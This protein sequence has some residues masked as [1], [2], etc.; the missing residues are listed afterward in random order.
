[1]MTE[2]KVENFEVGA[3]WHSFHRKPWRFGDFRL[4]SKAQRFVKICFDLS[5]SRISSPQGQTVQFCTSAEYFEVNFM[6]LLF[7]TQ[8][9]IYSYRVSWCDFIIMENDLQID[10]V[11]A[12]ITFQKVCKEIS[13]GIPSEA[14]SSL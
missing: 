6:Q 2:C 3:D 11:N 1:M 13:G 14:E 5:V 8:S 7:H 9:Q 4:K 12:T 10:V